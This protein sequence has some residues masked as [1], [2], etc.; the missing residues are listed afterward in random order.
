M[1]LD[2]GKCF[3][4]AFDVYK[5]NVLIIVLS[6]LLYLVITQFT[7]MILAGPVLAGYCIMLLNAM[8]SEAK[9][10]ELKDM[11][12]MFNRF[13]ALLGLFVLQILCFISLGGIFLG[14]M[15]MFIFF[16]AA[17]KKQNA[18]TCFETSWNVVR[19]NGFW[20]N[21]ALVVI[22]SLI[23]SLPGIL[24]QTVLNNNFAVAILVNSFTVPFGLLL[25]ASAYLQETSQEAAEIAP[26]E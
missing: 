2:I 9:K 26:A 1:A 22:G 21:F 18:L 5:R 15:W 3:N 20:T 12:S 19:K 17:D 11:F 14:T 16:I 23:M 25:I 24:L 8:R 7:L 4:D 6:G 13:G 10:I